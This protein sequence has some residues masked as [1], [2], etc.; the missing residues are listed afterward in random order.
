MTGQRS[1][2]TRNRQRLIDVAA[3][4]IA[5]QGVDVP[6]STI[7]DR[8]EVGPGT[9]YRHFPDRDSLLIAVFEDRIDRLCSRAPELAATLAPQA[10]LQEWLRIFVDHAISDNGLA[11]TLAVLRIKA[12]HECTARIHHAVETL[13]EAAITAGVVRP[14]HDAATLIRLYV[15]ISLA[16]GTPSEASDLLQIAWH[17]IETRDSPDRRQL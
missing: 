6:L 3:A 7:S 2:A 12:D 9:L 10:A 11:E 15:G 14:D 17:G 1:D 5:E 16:S 13:L 4:A 8:A